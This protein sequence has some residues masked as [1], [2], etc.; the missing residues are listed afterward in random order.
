MHGVLADMMQMS[1]LDM[2]ETVNSDAIDAFLTN[3]AWAPHMSAHKKMQKMPAQ[4]ETHE[5]VW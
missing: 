4:Q 5:E 1:G 3:A 2:S